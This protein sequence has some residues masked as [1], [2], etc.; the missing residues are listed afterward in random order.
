M[1]TAS[2]RILL[3][4][5]LLLPLLSGAAEL[6]PA[7]QVAFFEAKIRPVLVEH[8]YACHSAE[9]EKLKGGLRLDFRDGVLKG[10][11]TGLAV[12]PGKPD[13]SLLIQAIRHT[14]E[15]SAMPPK[16]KL[17]PEQI[18]DFERWVTIGAPDPRDKATPVDAPASK[19]DYAKAKQFWSF[20]TPAEK[21][22]PKVETVR[23]TQNPIDVFIAAKHAEK[24]VTAVGAASKRVM[25]RRATFDLTGLPPTPEEIEA[26]V[27]DASPDA[28]AKLLERL[29]ASPAYGERW[30]RHWLDVARYADT[31]GETADFP[32]PQAYRYRNYVISAFNTDKPYDQFIREQIAGDLLPV[33][34]TA[35][36]NDGIVA[37]G[38]LALSRRFGSDRA[39]QPMHLTIED[40][41]DTMGRAVM[42]LS[43]SC[44]RCHDHKFDPISS[45]DY[46]A[47]Y[48]IFQS[49]NYAFPGAEL[50]KKPA[51]FVPLVDAQ[52]AQQKKEFDAAIAPLDAE[53]AARTAEK[54]ALD[55]EMKEWV[56]QKKILASGVYENGGKQTF[57]EGK[58][59]AALARIE[60]KAGEM[61][62]LVILPKQ[63][64]GA[65]STVVDL[66]ITELDGQKRAW[67]FTREM[68][69]GFDAN[70]QNNPQ[71]DPFGN[72][73]WYVYDATSGLNML[74]NF[75]ISTFKDQKVPSI[76]NNEDTPSV[77]ANV[78]Q[79]P[80]SFITVTLPPRS[81][82]LH[83]APKG[84][85]ALAWESPA[86]GAFAIKGGV[87][88]VDTSGGD[89]IAWTIQVR[90]PVGAQAQKQKAINK[91]FTEAK[92]K[93]D[94][95]A[96]K[97]PVMQTAYAVAEG[98]P[99]NARIHR[100]GDVFNQG[101]EVPRRFLTL[102]GGQ[103]LPK[104]S[105]GSGRA[106]LAHWLTDPSNPLTARVM[107]NRIWQHHFGKGLVATPND[108]GTRGATPSHPELLDF[109]A[110]QF[111]QAGWSIKQMHRL[112]M[113][114]QA[115]QLA[116][117]DDAKS[118]GVDPNN[119]FLWRFN[120]QRLD[121]E[122]IRDAMLS[123]SGA[124][125]IASEPA[126][127][128]PHP[129]PPESSW[130]FTQHVPFNANYET[131][132]RSVYLMQQRIKKH[133]FLALFDGADSN[134]STG[135]RLESTTPIQALFILNDPFVHDCAGK[136]G[137]RL[138]QS[139][140]N[141]SER[142]ILAHQL[143]YGRSPT[144]AQVN[145]CE[146]FLKQ[147]IAKL[148]NAKD[149]EQKAW[150]GLSRVMLSSNEF[151]YVD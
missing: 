149:A 28:Y 110:R 46:Y 10:G 141:N 34:S 2:L 9:S 102:L 59:A 40:T 119:E 147:S 76:K 64:H 60:L 68:L 114:S 31:A 92:T 95:L 144:P 124:L 97:A 32:V 148:N 74:S 37:T 146:E 6:T 5:F 62:E 134:T 45:A 98:K 77:F 50:T 48:G 65:D 20:Q 117:A 72:A 13:E 53:L 73:P 82:G 7:E 140:P 39:D 63:N 38:F 54:T 36:R 25:V 66:E 22:L 58:D 133:P 71:K 79:A 55:K 129:F 81:V 61:L 84:P 120:R 18:K 109:L 89:G 104:E 87:T 24:G 135:L 30:G 130:A 16:A 8:C 15:D 113:S 93:R 33:K 100:R 128:G 35:E 106:E 86:A 103:A 17:S 115:Y 80:I 127:V 83:P 101:A 47:L 85:I 70:A 26:F 43:M 112:I 41:L 21:A 138:Q 57:A 19:I 125:E 12:V 151:L 139:K 52:Y 123:V 56:A 105:T 107:I 132:K 118:A 1:T 23:W 126:A 51:D 96:A 88:D 131:K 67:N 90:P 49:S 42:G 143:A 137:A 108:F 91:A 69:A 116:S 29:L 150:T 142:I 75:V 3:S 44:A 14:D 111:V 136:L 122:E 78:N 4:T 11:K 94:A 145:A 27:N 121:A 99:V